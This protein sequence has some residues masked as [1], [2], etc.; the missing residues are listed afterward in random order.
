MQAA[1]NFI[2]TEGDCRGKGEV[3]EEK[4]EEESSQRHSP[5]FS[6]RSVSP[7]N[8]QSKS[9]HELTMNSKCMYFIPKRRFFYVESYVLEIFYT[10]RLFWR[11]L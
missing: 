6:V 9:V 8:K 7:P 3:E 11:K 2:L 10:C 1:N 5:S 4:R